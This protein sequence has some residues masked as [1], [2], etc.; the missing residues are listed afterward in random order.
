MLIPSV[1]Q[2]LAGKLVGPQNQSTQISTLKSLLILYNY[3]GC[4]SPTTDKVE[5]SQP[6]HLL[7]WPL[8]SLVEVY[9]LRL[10][11]HRSYYDLQVEL[12][13][14]GR[15]VSPITESLSYQ[16]YIFWLQLFTL[17]K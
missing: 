17:S 4:S 2:I 14:S 1:S 16:K 5:K 9:G 3:A 6:E 7:F 10:S 13:T 8:K 15:R 11:L 12:R